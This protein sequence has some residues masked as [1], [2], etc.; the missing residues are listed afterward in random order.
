MLGDIY[1][2]LTLNGRFRMPLIPR[3]R[4]ANDPKSSHVRREKL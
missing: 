3:V 4:A 1:A 2:A